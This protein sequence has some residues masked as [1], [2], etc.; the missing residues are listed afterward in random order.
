MDVDKAQ[1][2]N[3]PVLPIVH[4]FCYHVPHDG[5]Y[6]LILHFCWVS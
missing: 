3:Y 2:S 6:E 1:C 4:I 5:I